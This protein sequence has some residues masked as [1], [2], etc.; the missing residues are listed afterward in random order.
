MLISLG[1][2][3]V[4]CRP[5]R[6]RCAIFDIHAMVHA[7]QRCQTAR[8]AE[9]LSDRRALCR[10]DFVCSIWGSAQ[11][12][13]LLP[14]GKKV[15][16]IGAG[17]GGVA[18]SLSLLKICNELNVLPPPEVH[19]FER[20]GSADAQTGLGYS[21][22]VRSDSGGLQVRQEAVC[23]TKRQEPQHR[24][25]RVPASAALVQHVS[26]IRS[27]TIPKHIAYKI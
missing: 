9:S 23:L 17:L 5:A 26:A 11:R 1:A 20:D 16:V 4:F 12:R 21:L 22:A 24:K 13:Q 19:L 6:G 15:Y 14:S 3:G 2:Y 10:C 7:C 8:I 18:F 25:N 27:N